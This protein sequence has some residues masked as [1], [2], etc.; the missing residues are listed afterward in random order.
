MQ[1]AGYLISLTIDYYKNYLYHLLSKDSGWEK[2]KPRLIV[3]NVC[4]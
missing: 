3:S 1:S 2:E 4:S